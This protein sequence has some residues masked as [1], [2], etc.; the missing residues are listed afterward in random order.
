[1]QDIYKNIKEKIDNSWIFQPILFIW[2]NLELVNKE[3]ENI[4][5]QLFKEYSVDKNFLYKI[6]DSDEKI[7]ILQVREFISKSVVK[8][9]FKFQIFVIENISRMNIESFNSSLKF[10]EEPWVWN[11]IFL[12]NHSESW[13]LDTVL[14]R[15]NIINLQKSVWEYKSDFFVTLIEDYLNKKNQNLIKYFFSDKKLEKKDYLDFLYTFIYYIKNINLNYSYLL[16]FLEESI[17]VIQKNNVLPKYEIDK[18][19]YKL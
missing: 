16:E 3:V 8:S 9:S 14:S 4:C 12:T 15:V 5:M 11:I 2:D 6:Q 18:I 17:S 10:L 13:I 19:I 1:M 7:K